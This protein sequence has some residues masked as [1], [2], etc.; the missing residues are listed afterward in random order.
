MLGKFEGDLGFGNLR[1]IALNLKL[2][3][4]EVESKFKSR[5][6]VKWEDLP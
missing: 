1:E 3:G 4:A 6:R 5:F 2:K